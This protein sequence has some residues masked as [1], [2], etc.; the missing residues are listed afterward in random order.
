MRPRLP[1][2][3]SDWPTRTWGEDDVNRLA[4]AA[5]ATA[6]AAGP[7]VLSPRAAS[8]PTPQTAIIDGAALSAAA[9]AVASVEPNFDFW[10]VFAESSMNNSLSHGLAAGFWPGFL[11]DAF[12]FIYGFQTTERGALGVSESQYPNP[13]QDAK[14]SS[15]GFLLGNFSQGCEF[16]FGRQGSTTDTCKRYAAPVLDPPGA[17]GTSETHSAP[18]SSNGAAHATRFTYPGILEAAD[19]QSATSSKFVDGHAR[20][21]A[22]FA[23]KDVTIGAQL[24]IDAI[25]ARSLSVAGG[26]PVAQ[27]E[28]SLAGVTFAG[29]S[30]RIDDQGVHVTGDQS[31]DAAN[32]SLA[33]QGI[34]VRL[35]QGRRQAGGD[36]VAASSGGLR[37][38]VFR[39]R[40]EEAFPM[41]VTSTRDAA[42]RSAQASPLS[43]EI[44]RLQYT[45][46]DPAF[47]RVP[48]APLPPDFQ[49]DQS[50]PPPFSCPF[51]NRSFDIGIV[52][53]LT[54]ADAR[55]TPLPAEQSF[56]GA[57]PPSSSGTTTTPA[58]RPA[59]AAPG[60]DTA[61]APAAL[62]PGPIGQ[63]VAEAVSPRLVSAQ[64]PGDVAA[65]V[66]VLYA[67][68]IVVLGFAVGGPYVLRTLSSP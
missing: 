68:L 7:L 56:A 47:G 15:T 10:P 51:L 50:V 2:I 55:L 3:L 13:P 43:A 34:E 14:A 40:A 29:Q 67:M 16:L 27:S 20:V 48:F 17:A 46:P 45:I 39:E 44:T 41:P 33:A 31:T 60:D 26:S 28:L 37:V 23:A 9:V 54:Q 42:C 59:P 5:L 30:A 62:E 22:I 21:E 24:H 63:P 18:L 6:L 53:G 11:I 38:R 58:S 25:R 12:F 49:I 65:G 64:Q 1:K 36:Q 61:A 35:V 19:V 8:A 4:A 32:A 52:L 66:R 57:L